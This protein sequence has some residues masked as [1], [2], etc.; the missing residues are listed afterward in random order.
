M[1]KYLGLCLLL[2]TYRNVDPPPPPD[3]CLFTKHTWLY[4]FSHKH[5]MLCV[6]VWCPGEAFQQRRDVVGH[7]RLRPAGVLRYRETPL[8]GPSTWRRAAEGRWD[9]SLQS[10]FQ[11]FPHQELSSQTYSY[12]WGEFMFILL[13]FI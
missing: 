9:L 8:C 6:Q 4:L 1:L 7:E 3:I 11:E 5:I 13:F 10:G 12:R 2:K